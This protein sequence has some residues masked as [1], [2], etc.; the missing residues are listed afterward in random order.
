MVTRIGKRG[1][2]GGA[3]H[4]D[5]LRYNQ[6]DM[7]LVVGIYEVAERVADEQAMRSEPMRA[8]SVVEDF[9]TD[10]FMV[11]DHQEALALETRDNDRFGIQYTA[12]HY[13]GEEITPA[14]GAAQI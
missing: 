3:G 4:D 13:E 7:S 12:G 8:Y 11:M 10:E 5:G 9:E 6:E 1:K 2:D 14:Q